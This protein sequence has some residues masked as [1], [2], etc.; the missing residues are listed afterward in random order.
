MPTDRVTRRAWAKVNLALSLGAPVDA[1]ESRRGWHPIAT[2]TAAIELW[3]EVTAERL[4][5]G[6]SSRCDVSWAPDAPRPTPIDWPVER[7]LAAR[8]HR[9]LEREAGRALPASIRVRKRIPVGAGLGGGS[10]DAAAALRALD[11]LFGLGV[12]T[13]RLARLGAELGSDVAFFLDE[14]AEDGGAAALRAD[15]PPRPAIVAGFGERVDRLPTVQGTAVVL[16]VPAF[17]CPTREVYRA[18][19]ELGAARLREP[20]VRRMGESARPLEEALFNDLAPAAERMRPGLGAFRA[21]VAA[22]AGRAAHVTGSG[23]A[24]FVPAPDD[25]AAAMARAVRAGVPGATVGAW[26]IVPGPARTAG[27]A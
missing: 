10:S 21:A 8:A 18:F 20:E 24:V 6:A 16:A 13:A 25:E 3:D 12:G 11:A 1:P 15:T 5:P 23:S 19:D 17:S 26:R 14:A 22:A 9:L 27:G 2:W 4:P 7:D